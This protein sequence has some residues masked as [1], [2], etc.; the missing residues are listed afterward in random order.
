MSDIVAP[1]VPAKE[2]SDQV[3][4]EDMA[5]LLKSEQKRSEELERR[6]QEAQAR[7]SKAERDV[8]EAGSRVDHGELARYQ[9]QQTAVESAISAATAEIDRLEQDVAVMHADGKYAEA[10]KLVR[11]MTE[12]QARLQQYEQRKDWLGEQKQ[13]F[14]AEAQQR[15]TQRQAQ[16]ADPLANYTPAAR[17]WIEKHPEFLTD[18][19]YQ[20]RVIEGHHAALGARH[21]EGSPGYFAA[22]EA[23][24][25]PK[26]PAAEAEEEGEEA[27]EPAAERPRP[28]QPVAMPVQRQTPQT[29]ARQTS[30]KL[31]ADER[32]MAD[33]TMAWIADPVERYKTYADNRAKLKAEG[34]I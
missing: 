6:F 28:R 5:K 29:A 31:S 32:E 12:Q 26:R 23:H 13:R 33:A 3:S 34:R 25:A 16:Q 1:D 14:E 4:A 9:A 15:Q 11:R 20:Q 2:E 21:K 27:E 30:I 18:P 19:A 7:A 10:A 8:S 17:Q 24:L 22:I